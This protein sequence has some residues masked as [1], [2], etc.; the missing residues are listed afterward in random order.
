MIRSSNSFFR[1]DPIG[2]RLSDHSEQMCGSAKLRECLGQLLSELA[3][4][5]L[6]PLRQQWQKITKEI[7]HA[8]WLHISQLDAGYLGPLTRRDCAGLGFIRFKVR[9]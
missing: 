9:V 8:P 5:K 7:L 3:Q 1:D 2:Q 6:I 4:D